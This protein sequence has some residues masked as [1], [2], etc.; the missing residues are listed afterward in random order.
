LNQVLVLLNSPSRMTKKN[1]TESVERESGPVAFRFA[2]IMKPPQF[3]GD[4]DD[5]E[6]VSSEWQAWKASMNNFIAYIKEAGQPLPKSHEVRVRLSGLRGQ[7][8]L[9][10]SDK[11]EELDTPNWKEIEQYLDTIFLGSVNAHSLIA[12][13]KTIKQTPG[14]SVS[15]YASEFNAI[16]RRLVKIGVSNRDVSAQWFVD[17]LLPKLGKLVNEKLMEDQPLKDYDI[18]D[19]MGAVAKVTNLALSKEMAGRRSEKDNDRWEHG[20][21]SN[22]WRRGGGVQRNGLTG[23]RN[24]LNAQ[25]NSVAV[26]FATFLGVSHDTIEKRMKA[27]ECLTCGSSSHQIRACPKIRQAS[28]HFIDADEEDRPKKE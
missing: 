20:S 11:I 22:N 14:K 18:N 26:D 10:A 13:L 27:K 8:M 5:I 12:L 23:Q 21:K 7:A 28:V 24:N 17:G 6:T 2:D 3:S 19:A 25:M 1:L 9:C 16:H 15:Q 4:G